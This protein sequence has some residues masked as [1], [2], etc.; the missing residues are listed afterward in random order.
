M[1]IPVYRRIL[2]GATH[3]S[4]IFTIKVQQHTETQ[5]CARDMATI[6][7][8]EKGQ[9]WIFSLLVS[10]I[11]QDRV[12]YAPKRCLG[13]PSSEPLPPGSQQ[14][15][16][17]HGYSFLSI[18]TIISGLQTNLHRPDFIDSN[19]RHKWIGSSKP[20]CSFKTLRLYHGVTCYGFQIPW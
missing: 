3:F 6:K 16:F 20:L 11:P 10:I 13:R 15:S 17:S 7:G 2:F 19:T 14:G 12:W 8:A 5:L 4:S 9:V 18:C 1:P